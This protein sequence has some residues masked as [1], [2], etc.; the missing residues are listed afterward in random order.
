MDKRNPS[1]LLPDPDQKM[2]VEGHVA[3]LQIVLVT[4][5][6]GEGGGQVA[7]VVETETVNLDLLGKIHSVV[8]SQ[9]VD[10]FLGAPVDGQ[11]LVLAVVVEIIDFILGEGLLLDRGEVPVQRLAVYSD[12]LV[13]IENHCN[14]FIGVG[15]ADV[16]GVV[17]DVRLAVIVM[18]EVNLI[19]EHCV[20]Q[21]P[22]S[23][24]L[25]AERFTS[26]I[27][28]FLKFV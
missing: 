21:C 5:I 27:G 20:Q 18:G 14:V 1:V 24:L 4:V 15:D 2:A 28:D 7:F 10:C 11:L 17:L 6:V 8:R 12:L 9:L 26:D 22:Y 13:L 23:K 16:D 19:L 3:E 25:L